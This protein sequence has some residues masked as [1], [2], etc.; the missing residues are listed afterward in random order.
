MCQKSSLNIISKSAYGYVGYCNGC[1]RYN[2]VFENIFILLKEEEIR[3][4]GAI[5][6]VEYGTYIM[7]KPVG[8]GK[9]ISFQTP[10]ANTFFAFTAC[11]Y[12]EF[13]RM[14]NESVLMLEVNEI[15]NQK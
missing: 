4:L 1:D 15:I 2:L 10:L 7:E 6:D 11:E 14:I 8:R 5:V 12:E 9:T 3:G 13:K